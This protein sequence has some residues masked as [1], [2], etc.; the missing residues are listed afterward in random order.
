LVLV[1]KLIGWVACFC[2]DVSVSCPSRIQAWL[3]QRRLGR[4]RHDFG[5]RARSGRATARGVLA[6]WRR[7]E[8]PGSENAL[9]S[10]PNWSTR[11][12]SCS[13]SWSRSSSSS[14]L[15][16][17]SPALRSGRPPGPSWRLALFRLLG[18]LGRDQGC[19]TR[20]SAREVALETG[21][22]R[23]VFP[24]SNQG[25]SDSAY[26]LGLMTSPRTL[27]RPMREYSKAMAAA[28]R[29]ARLVTVLPSI[30]DM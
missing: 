28:N 4:G 18:R 15:S 6:T 24:G 7:G 11:S 3:R 10:T 8:R 2:T 30:R 9:H 19:A 26:V 5:V 20:N 21:T 23:Y 22:S 29:S 27:I 16:K 13:R 17:R 14:P 25:T 1:D 12:A